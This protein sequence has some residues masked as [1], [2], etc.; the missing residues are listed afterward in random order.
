MEPIHFGIRRDLQADIRHEPNACDGYVLDLSLGCSHQ[1]NYCIFSPLE[2][3]IYRLFDPDYHDQVIPLKLDRFLARDTFPPAVYMCYASDPLAGA[4][5]RQ[6]TKTVLKKLFE[7]D[8]RV[9]FITKGLFTD[10]VLDVIAQRPDLMEIQVGIANCDDAR[11]R[12]IEPGVPSYDTRLANF[13]K[14]MSIPRLGSLVV[15]M[16]PLFP[17]IDDTPGNVNRILTD[18]ASL[19]VKE[20]VFGYVILTANLRQELKQVPELAASM[21][22]LSE[23][24]PTISNRPLYSFPFAEKVERLELFNELCAR[25][26]ITMAACGCKDERLKTLPIHWV[27]HPFKRREERASLMEAEGAVLS[28]ERAALKAQG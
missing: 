19:G 26:N 25:Q 21:Q 9:L 10:D 3:K 8:V 5:M 17:K 27:C 20:A 14:L 13:E 6:S 4:A 16:D 23:K 1:C 2:R 22:A 28:G 18:V 15:R 24:T 12:L 11:N 7:H